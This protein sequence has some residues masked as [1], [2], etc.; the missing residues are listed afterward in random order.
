M[1]GTPVIFNVAYTPYKLKKG[2]TEKEIKAHAEKRAYYDFT[3]DTNYLRYMTTEGMISKDE[4]KEMKLRLKE[5]K[6]NIWS[7]FVSFDEE[8]SEKIDTPE[9]CIALIRKT[10]NEFFLCEKKP[11]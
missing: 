11:R 9:K 1:S 4:L 3:G 5:N 7:G 10:F 6:G 2:S 8:N